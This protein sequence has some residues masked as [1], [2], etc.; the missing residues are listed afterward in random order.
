MT[1]VRKALLLSIIVMSVFPT[2]CSFTQGSSPPTSIEMGI[3]T[4]DIWFYDSFRI[5]DEA[6]KPVDITDQILAEAKSSLGPPQALNPDMTFRKT[7]KVEGRVVDEDGELLPS[8]TLDFGVLDYGDR[9]LL[10]AISSADL[11]E[12]FI[13]LDRDDSVEI[14]L[15]FIDEL[16]VGDETEMDYVF[17][18]TIVPDDV[19]KEEGLTHLEIFL[20]RWNSGNFVFLGIEVDDEIRISEMYGQGAIIV[21]GSKFWRY[22]GKVMEVSGDTI[23]G[24]FQGVVG[25]GGTGVVVGGGVG[26]L[27][28]P[29]AAVSCPV[30]AAW[31]GLVGVVIGGWA[32]TIGGFLSSAG[33]AIERNNPAV[34]PP[35]PPLQSPSATSPP[36]TAPPL[37]PV[38]P[39]PTPVIVMVTDEPGDCQTPTGIIV[40]TCNIDVLE[41]VYGWDSSRQE[42]YA[43][44]TFE[45]DPLETASVG[46]PINLDN[47]QQTGF[48]WDQYLGIDYHWWFEG[49]ENGVLTPGPGGGQEATNIPGAVSRYDNPWRFGWTLESILFPPLPGQS[50]TLGDTV[51]INYIPAQSQYLSTDLTTFV[52]GLEIWDYG[53]NG[54]NMVL[55]LVEPVEITLPTSGE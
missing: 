15:S 52:I 13:N 38:T 16:E 22:T 26:L 42:F 27:G 9:D 53:V 28:G 39:S 50:K 8:I 6:G 35:P 41:V 29:F 7:T 51:A 24:G 32:G 12:A 19:S 18:Q 37:P 47:D 44:I 48:S 54:Q 43:L 31:G 14:D 1:I 21:K 30:G 25:G 33:A 5:F 11:D 3:G 45:G 20:D 40:D 49:E 46:F 36:P 10:V 17:A 23:K 55:E 2:S 4:Q 34:P